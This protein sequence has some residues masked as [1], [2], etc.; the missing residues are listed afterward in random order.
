MQTGIRN[1]WLRRGQLCARPPPS[2]RNGPRVL[3]GGVDLPCHFGMAAWLPLSR[4]PS[5]S[6]QKIYHQNPDFKIA[7]VVGC[8]G[9]S[10]L[11][12]ENQVSK[13]SSGAVSDMSC[14]KLRG[15]HWPKELEGWHLHMR[16]SQRKLFEGSL[17]RAVGCS[18]Q[19]AVCN[20]SLSKTC[21]QGDSLR[22]QC[23]ML[24]QKSA[25]RRSGDGS[26]E[27]ELQRD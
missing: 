4:K 18:L 8:S 16:R 25:V 2:P 23:S 19:R 9:T 26:H 17:Q 13:C 5:I 20:V 6:I 12:L 22:S 14:Q 11:G 10:K 27:H 7:V 21:S 24:R 15:L 3:Y 1:D